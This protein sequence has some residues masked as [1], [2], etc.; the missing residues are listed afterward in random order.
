MIFRKVVFTVCVA[1]G[2]SLAS[3]P[4]PESVSAQ[5][6]LEGTIRAAATG[7]PLPGAQVDIPELSL[8]GITGPAGH[9][10]VTGIP[11][12][13]HTVRIT[14]IGYTATRITVAGN[15]PYPRACQPIVCEDVEAALRPRRQPTPVS[16]FTETLATLAWPLSFLLAY[17]QVIT[18]LPH[19]S[20]A[21]TV[22]ARPPT[23]PTSP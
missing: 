4:L 1:V 6:G 9:Y 22:P 18:V 20:R 10:E 8:G 7:Q 14:L 5:G 19:R 23:R 21:S 11:A 16:H 17:C 12:G 3:L 15:Q 2:V 13:S